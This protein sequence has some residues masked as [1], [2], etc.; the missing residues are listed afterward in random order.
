[1]NSPSFFSLCFFYY[2]ICVANEINVL[3]KISFVLHA[4][5][6]SWGMQKRQYMGLQLRN[7]IIIFSRFCGKLYLANVEKLLM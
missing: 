7:G 5:I 3:E 1:M 2:L 6:F 4:L